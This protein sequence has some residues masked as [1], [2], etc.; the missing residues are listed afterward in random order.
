MKMRSG[1]APLIIIVVIAA[2]AVIGGGAVIV[3]RT[4]YLDFILPSTVREFLHRGGAVPSS[5]SSSETPSETPEPEDPTKDWKTYTSSKHGFSFKYPKDWRTAVLADGEVLLFGPHAKR[6]ELRSRPQLTIYPI[7]GWGSDYGFDNPGY[8]L[9]GEESVWD[10]EE[11]TASVGGRNAIRSEH[12]YKP[13]KSIYLVDIDFSRL[14]DDNKM[15][16]E[17]FPLDGKLELFESILTTFRF[18]EE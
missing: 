17:I 7:G 10:V 5:E 15:R 9:T 2:V 12:T 14:S 16:L 8:D 13:R 4:T 11:R 6:L 1:F 18:L 3:R